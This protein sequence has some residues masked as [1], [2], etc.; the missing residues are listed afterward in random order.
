MVGLGVLGWLVT[1]RF[2]ANMRFSALGVF[3]AVAVAVLDL[4]WCLGEPATRKPGIAT[5]TEMLDLEV[6]DWLTVDK[7]GTQINNHWALRILQFVVPGLSTFLALRKQL[8]RIALGYYWAAYQAFARGLLVIAGAWASTAFIWFVLSNWVAEEVCCNDN[9]DIYRNVHGINFAFANEYRQ[10]NGIAFGAWAGL[11]WVSVTIFQKAYKIQTAAKNRPKP[12]D[13]KKHMQRELIVPA[14]EAP[15][16]SGQRIGMGWRQ[17]GMVFTDPES[18]LLLLGPPRVGKSSCV[19]GPAIARWKGPV[20]VTSTKR[21]VFDWT[22]K[23]R[24][25]AGRPAAIFDPADT[26]FGIPGGPGRDRLMFTWSPL[27]GAQDYEIARLTARSMIGALPRDAGGTYWR[28]RGSQLLGAL[29]HVCAVTHGQ[30]DTTAEAD[31]ETSETPK[32]AHLGSDAIRTLLSWASSYSVAEA[33]KRAYAPGVEAD[34]AALKLLEGVNETDKRE[35]SGYWSNVA[36]VLDGLGSETYLAQYDRQASRIPLRDLARHG[37]LTFYIIVPGDVQAAM[38]PVVVAMIDALRREI[39]NYWREQRLPKLDG[40]LHH[41]EPEPWLFALD[42]L[43]NIAPLPGLPSLLSEGA[44]QGIVVCGSLQDLNQA[45]TRWEHEAKGLMSLF[46][47][48]VAFPG[49]RDQ[50]TLELISLLYGEQEQ[51]QLS[52]STGTTVGKET[53]TTSSTQ[54]TW[55]WR[56]AVLPAQIS[57]PGQLETL[58]VL[59]PRGSMPYEVI[60]DETYRS[61]FFP[62]VAARR[63]PEPPPSYGYRPPPRQPPG[64]RPDREPAIDLTRQPWGETVDLNGEERRI[65]RFPFQRP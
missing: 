22:F 65:G 19:L 3:F 21:D 10:F 42:E 24:Q 32:A 56:R 1:G 54:E 41:P 44:S 36:R 6:T 33:L 15:F 23:L 47:T 46:G 31:A 35:A 2:L 25:E 12:S 50:E 59:P 16:W 20:L 37:P 27:D 30:E 34:P 64:G 38:A 14:D 63:P 60:L 39:Y 29:L 4:S 51:R 45:R 55:Q 13:D 40:R 43:A 58:R 26:I 7:V 48:V 8:R 61:Q 18:H 28:D 49:I 11:V 17:D 57:A 53:S 62:D 52:H 9:G 5:A